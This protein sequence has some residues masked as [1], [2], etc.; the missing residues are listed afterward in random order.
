MLNDDKKLKAALQT[1]LEQSDGITVCMPSEVVH[2]LLSRAGTDMVATPVDMVLFCPNCNYQH[3]DAEDE[4][5]PASAGI[6]RWTNPPHRSHLCHSCGHEW[7]PADVE[8]NGVA[9]VKTKGK[10]DSAIVARAATVVPASIWKTTHKAVCDPITEDKE[11]ADQWKANGYDVIAYSTSPAP[12]SAHTMTRQALYDLI[13]GVLT[14]HGLSYTCDDNG[15]KYPL[16]DKLSAPGDSSTKTG[17]DEVAL[18]AEAVLD[19]L[20]TTVRVFSATTAA[21]HAGVGVDKLREAMRILADLAKGVGRPELLPTEAD[22]V[23]D[24]LCSPLA[25]LGA[26]LSR[27]TASTV[28]APAAAR[29]IARAQDGRQA[30]VSEEIDEG[31]EIIDNLIDSVTAHGNYSPEATISFLSQARQ[32]FKSASQSSAKSPAGC[33]RTIDE[34]AAVKFY[35]ANPTAALFDLKQRLH[36]VA[37]QRVEPVAADSKPSAPEHVANAATMEKNEC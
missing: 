5:E 4:P 29:F 23:H 37:P 18:L 3:I 9:A 36:G 33:E 24:W 22:K 21:A 8:T 28:A 25:K 12:Q 11:I 10:R 31:I 19:V 32:C 15:E 13:H 20:P 34:Q 26:I 2:A 17:K 1:Y 35:R 6:P 16:V 30:C 7:R 14:E 27:G